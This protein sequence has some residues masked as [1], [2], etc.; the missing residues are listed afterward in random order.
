[1]Q[2]RLAAQ[3]E[4]AARTK[5]DRDPAVRELVQV[6]LKSTNLYARLHAMWGMGQIA[7]RLNHEQLVA[8]FEKLL[9]LLQDANAMI[10]THACTVFQKAAFA[11]A[12]G[13]VVRML[14]DTNPTVRFHAG[15][16]T[17]KEWTLRSGEYRL[18]QTAGEKLS[19]AVLPGLVKLK[20]SVTSTKSTHYSRDYSY[21]HF[22]GIAEAALGAAG[23]SGDASGLHGV[24]SVLRVS[25]ARALNRHGTLTNNYYWWECATNRSEHVRLTTLLAMRRLGATEIARFLRDPDPRLVLEAAHQRC[26]H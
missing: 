9:P 6:A 12:R 1:M 25:F 15:I 18:F 20:G 4:L 26:R 22:G 21:T 2:V 3:F 11:N 7:E 23:K 8:D 14:A 24:G 10:R 5:S 13:A 19:D 16:A 17:G